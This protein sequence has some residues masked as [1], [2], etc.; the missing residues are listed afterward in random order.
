MNGGLGGLKKQRGWMVWIY[1]WMDAG[2][3]IGWLL[4]NEWMNGKKWIDEYVQGTRNE[5]IN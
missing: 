1:K 3:Q 4:L 2:S 5:E